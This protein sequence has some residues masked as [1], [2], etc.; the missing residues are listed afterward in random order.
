MSAEGAARSV[1]SV[2]LLIIGLLFLVF[3]AV[4]FFA[5]FG[6]L[7]CLLLVVFGVIFLVISGRV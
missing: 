4:D 3:A 1:V 2:I 5:G 6:L 7:Y